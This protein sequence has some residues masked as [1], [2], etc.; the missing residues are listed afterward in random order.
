MMRR[1]KRNTYYDRF[2]KTSIVFSCMVKY[3]MLS[4]SDI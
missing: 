2:G 4:A 1:R 3:D